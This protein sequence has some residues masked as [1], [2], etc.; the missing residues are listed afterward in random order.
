MS[1]KKYV[2]YSQWLVNAPLRPC[3]MFFVVQVCT[4]KW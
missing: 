2:K 1:L 4:N 3:V